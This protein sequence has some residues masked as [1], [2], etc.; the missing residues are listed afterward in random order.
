MMISLK[1]LRE[2]LPAG[3]VIAVYNF[4]LKTLGKR[5]IIKQT[6]KEMLCEILDENENES[7]KESYLPWK[8]LQAD[9]NESGDIILTDKNTKVKYFQIGIIK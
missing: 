2:Y 6:E 8:G 1:K 3:T 7:G 4:N 9:I 5:K